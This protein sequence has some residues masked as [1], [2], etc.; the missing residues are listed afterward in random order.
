MVRRTRRVTGPAVHLYFSDHFDVP[1]RAVERYGA[2]DISLVADLPA[3]IDP[4]LLFNSRRPIYRRLHAE[5]IRYLIFLRDKSEA[6]ALDDALIR[7]WYAFKEVR[8]TWLGFSEQGNRGQGLGADFAHALHRNLHHLGFGHETI[9]KSSHLEKLCLIEGRVGRDKISDFTTR[10]ILRHLCQYTEAFAKRYLPRRLKR[11]VFVQRVSFDYRHERWRPRRYT[12]P[13]HRGEFVLLTPR[14]LLT[15]D[16]TWINR[17]DLI[18]SL[19]ALPDAIP[20]AEL[21]HQVSS[22]FRKLLP[23]RPKQKDKRLAAAETIRRFPELIDYYIRHKEDDGAHAVS[24]SRERVAYV[25]G[26]FIHQCK[27]LVEALARNTSFYGIA[28]DTYQEARQRLGFL[29]EEIEDRGGWRIFYHR[30][31]PIEREK[32][33]Q[34]LYQLTWCGSSSD[35][36][37]EANAGRGPVDFAVS[38]GS[39]DKSVVEFKLASN[40]H[41]R[42]NL[43][44]QVKVYKKSQ[45]AH[46]A[47]TAILFFSKVQEARVRGILKEVGLTGHQD[48]VLIDARADNKPSGSKA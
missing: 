21:R 22:Y 13:W 44:R 31:E 5:V 14:D 47:L 4:F 36:N 43:E 11:R 17:A 3:F 28:G 10:L 32:D 26:V 30:G 46:H 24:I 18:D 6:A 8:Q 19:E 1:R 37:P 23:R 45:R 35:L 25:E 48:I 40:P 16:E 34:I 33:V 27:Q 29:K 20:N 39:A 42:R 38:R 12:L 2:L 9:T 7:S 41:L 15:K